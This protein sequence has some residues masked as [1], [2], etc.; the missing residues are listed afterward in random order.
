M[1]AFVPV[2]SANTVRVMSTN[3]H[4]VVEQAARDLVF[5]LSNC[6]IV[7][8]FRVADSQG[9]VACLILVW[10]ATE[11]MP[12]I[13]LDLERRR[14]SNGGRIACKK[15]IIDIIHTSNCP[16]TRKEILKALR[17]NGKIHGTGTVAKALADLTTLG[18]L[19]NQK[20]K[21]GY[22]LPT[23]IRRQKTPSLFE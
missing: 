7:P 22:R 23:W 5:T 16:L 11:A 1:S 13:D 3:P 17:Q 18:E 20:D 15:D 8:T 4:D 19:V 9:K 14:R 2:C 10:D 21:K 12:A 6:P